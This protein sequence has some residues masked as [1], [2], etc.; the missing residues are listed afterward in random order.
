MEGEEIKMK[1]ECPQRGGG[2]GERQW[3]VEERAHLHCL[4][5]STRLPP[6]FLSR[7]CPVSG[8]SGI[9]FCYQKVAV[10]CMMVYLL[11]I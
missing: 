6:L 10:T 8:F 4:P 7:F 3:C 1:N 9:G 11:F 5:T 2:G